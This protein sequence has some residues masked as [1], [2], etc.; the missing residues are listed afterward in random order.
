M[1]MKTTE[2]QLSATQWVFSLNVSNLIAYIFSQE[3]KCT[4]GEVLRTKSQAASYAA[5][6]VGVADS[7]HCKRLAID[8]CLFSPSGKY[9]KDS[10]DYKIF[11]DYW[12]SLHPYN[13]W[14]GNFRR[15][16]GNHFEMREKK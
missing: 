2:L 9:L 15:A 14:G 5:D 4:L 7:Q 1:I 11:G 16:D 6:G 8:I 3:Y 12:E 10:E 13:R